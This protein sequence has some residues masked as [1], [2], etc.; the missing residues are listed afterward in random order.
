VAPAD[1]AIEATAATDQAAAGATRKRRRPSRARGRSG[2]P[3]SAHVTEGQLSST[4]PAD[5]AEMRDIASDLS[6]MVRTVPQFTADW[7]SDVLP[8]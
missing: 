6:A 4:R 3:A 7:P 8:R 1:Q 5:H 2:R